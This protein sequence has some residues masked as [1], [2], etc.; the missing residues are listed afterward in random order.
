MTSEPGHTIWTPEETHKRYSEHFVE[1]ESALDSILLEINKSLASDEIKSYS[2]TGRCKDPLSLFV[3]Q[4][5]PPRGKSDSYRYDNPWTECSD[6]LGVRIIVQ[7]ASDKQRVIRSI[8]KI[9]AF[10]VLEIDD[11]ELKREFN[12]LTYGGLHLDL[13]CTALTTQLSRS[14]RCEIQIRTL[15]EHTWAETEHEFIYKGPA[16]IPKE[17]QRQFARVLALVELLD[18]EL[19]RGVQSVSNLE[20]FAFLR[21]SK[22]IS[23]AAKSISWSQ[24]SHKLSMQNIEEICVR[25]GRDVDELIQLIVRF[26]EI[27]R[28]MLDRVRIAIGPSSN[29]FDIRYHALVAQP[30]C[31]LIAALLKDNPMALSTAMMSSDLHDQIVPIAREMGLS[32]S[33][34]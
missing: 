16:G 28:G 1:Y 25:T 34:L 27:D 12:E 33:F 31:I 2:V 6:L 9:D 18:L 10:K 3:K 21:I 22:A 32:R 23:V 20:T 26:S 11:K 7:L 4:G 14:I 15:A 8:Q 19:D 13:L 17:T 29:R 30:E 24:G 5:K